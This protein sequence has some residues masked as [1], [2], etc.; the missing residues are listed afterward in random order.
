MEAAITFLTEA[1]PFDAY[2]FDSMDGTQSG[3]TY[4]WVLQDPSFSHVDPTLRDLIMRCQLEVPGERPSITTL[5]REIA[6]RKMHP[7][8]QSPE[9]MAYFWECF[10]GPKTP[11]PIPDPGDVCLDFKM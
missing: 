3:N 9:E 7:F 1:Y 5:L 10:F 4:G 8:Y 11:E 6:I 2:R